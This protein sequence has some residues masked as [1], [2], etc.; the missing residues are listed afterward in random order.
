VG[1]SPSQRCSFK[2][3]RSTTQLLAQ[4]IPSTVSTGTKLKPSPFR[5]ASRSGHLRS[6]SVE[7]C[8]ELLRRR[9]LPLPE[10]SFPRPPDC[11]G[12]PLSVTPREE[13][14][15]HSQAARFSGFSPH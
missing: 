13:L 8:L 10:D 6:L 9:S 4:S 12:T 15:L 11:G 2:P 1:E 7:E 3:Q 14:C 5:N